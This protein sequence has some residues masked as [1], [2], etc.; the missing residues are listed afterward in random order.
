M[1]QVRQ[2]ARLKR[3]SIRTETSYTYYIHQFILF[4]NKRHPKDLGIPEIRA[5]LSHLAI[6]GQVAASTQ[7]VAQFGMML[8]LTQSGLT[9]RNCRFS[10]SM[11][12]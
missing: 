11:D 8:G 4:H 3:L 12:G 1:D 10:A 7:N 5:V 9:A 6:Q 2:V